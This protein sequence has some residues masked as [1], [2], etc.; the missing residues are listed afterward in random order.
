MD[1]VPL[2]TNQKVR[3][4]P[5]LRRN[6]RLTWC[7]VSAVPLD[8]NGNDPDGVFYGRGPHKGCWM[9]PLYQLNYPDG[10][11]V[12]FRLKPWVRA[13]EYLRRLYP[14]AEIVWGEILMPNSVE[15]DH[16]QGKPINWRVP[17]VAAPVAKVRKG[18]TGPLSGPYSA[19]RRYE[20][21]RNDQAD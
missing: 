14:K 15:F 20:W 11:W 5:P 8:L 1:T 6:K 9:M 13:R 17:D 16:A 21:R 19:D 4:L 18:K 2:N 3:D 7:R 10:S 12:R